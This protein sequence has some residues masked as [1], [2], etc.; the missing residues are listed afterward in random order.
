MSM[1]LTLLKKMK[2][3]TSTE[4]L[5]SRPFLSNMNLKFSTSI[6]PTRVIFILVIYFILPLYNTSQLIVKTQLRSMVL[7][8]TEKTAVTDAVHFLVEQQTVFC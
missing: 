3:R 5:L 4:G 7:N 6:P 8:R 2:V 1:Q